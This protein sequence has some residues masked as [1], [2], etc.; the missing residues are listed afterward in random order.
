M[1]PALHSPAHASRSGGGRAQPVTQRGAALDGRVPGATL[2]S[3]E[4]P[5][6][7]A[8]ALALCSTGATTPSSHPL[9]RFIFEA[10]IADRRRESA[11][12]RVAQL[13]VEEMIAE[14]LADQKAA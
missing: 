8:R 5:A 11:G 12:H 2:S 3:P 10:A 7:E 1:W 6:D 4:L 13:A 14:R 9:P